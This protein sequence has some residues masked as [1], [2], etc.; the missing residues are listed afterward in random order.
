MEGDADD[1]KPV[2]IVVNGQNIPLVIECRTWTL[3]TEI[4]DNIRFN[5]KRATPRVLARRGLAMMRDHPVAIVGGGPSLRHTMGELRDFKAIL[6]CGSVHDY[7][8][9]HGITP[10]FCAVADSI[11]TM[12]DCIRKPQKDCI[13]AVASQCHPSLFEALEGYNVEM[14]HFKGQLESEEREREV[15]GTEMAICCGCTVGLNAIYLALLFGYQH[16]HFFGFDSSYEDELSHSYEMEDLRQV[17]T[18]MVMAEGSGRK[19]KTDMGMIAQAEQFFK[20]VEINGQW[21]HCYIHGDG[22]IAEMVRTG[23][24][25]MRKYITVVT[26]SDVDDSYPQNNLGACD[27]NG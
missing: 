16:L 14:W 6:A 21:F 20:I 7:L 9:D 3:P 11:E 15:L 17:Q 19:I 4:A 22:L 8:V 2:R 23:N 25:E 12:K 5:I 1:N 27:G 10:T 26:S 18:Q 13:Y 24:D